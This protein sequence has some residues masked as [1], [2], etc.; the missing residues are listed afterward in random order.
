MP[1]T[2]SQPTSQIEPYSRPQILK[3]S[4]GEPKHTQK[5][6][7]MEMRRENPNTCLFVS[8][9]RLDRN[10][11]GLSLGISIQKTKLVLCPVVESTPVLVK[12]CSESQPAESV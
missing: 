1:I 10:V 7:A 6:V 11:F 3:T 2:P 5:E 9:T 4:Q 8:E 12:I